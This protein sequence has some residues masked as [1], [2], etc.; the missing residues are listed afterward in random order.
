MLKVKIGSKEYQLDSL[1]SNDLKI[2][3][4][5]KEKEKL[6]DYDYAHAVMLH[7]V[8]KF[9]PDVKMTLNEFMDIFPLKGMEEKLIEIGEIIGLDFKTGIGK[10]EIGKKK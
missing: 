10:S 5:E 4:A 9:N 8:K 2:L 1:V 6:S 7:A 3:E